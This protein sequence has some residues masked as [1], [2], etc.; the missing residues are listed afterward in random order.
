MSASKKILFLDD[1]SLSFSSPSTQIEL[2]HSL[3]LSLHKGE[4]LCLLGKSGIGKSQIFHSILQTLPFN[5]SLKGKIWFHKEDLLSFPS[6]IKEIRGRQIAT[7]FQDPES[8]L[9]PHQTIQT[10]IF[11]MLSLHR[12]LPFEKMRQRCREMFHKIGLTSFNQ[13]LQKFPHQLSGGQ[14]QRILIARALLCSPEILLADEPTTALDEKNRQRVFQLLLE[15]KKRGL[16]TLLI[17]HD[18]QVVRQLADRIALLHSGQ[19]IEEGTL[20]QLSCSP[21]HPYTSEFFSSFFE[22]PSLITKFHPKDLSSS[23]PLL[24]PKSPPLL[25]IENLSTPHLVKKN[26]LF[27]TTLQRPILQKIS[28]AINRGSSLGIWGESGGG[29]TTLAKSIM[30]LLAHSGK[31][32]LNQCLLESLPT[33]QL[34]KKRRQMQIIFQHPYSSLNPTK[35]IKKILDFPLKI[36]YPSLSQKERERQIDHALSLVHL[37]TEVKKLFPHELSG[38]QCQRVSIARSMIIHPELLICDEITSS[39][40]PFT[41]KQIIKLLKELQ[42]EHNMSLLFISHDSHAI[43]QLCDKVLF[44][45]EG[46]LLKKIDLEK[47]SLI[48]PLSLSRAL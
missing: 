1:L 36:H 26:S 30:Q 28:F 14:K 41:K 16:S 22:S 7:I 21:S 20:N 29:K 9:T 48:H 42:R 43:Q 32:L 23:Q 47:N 25:S 40:D 37:P 34:Q 2:I 13:I 35:Q 8:S 12:K 27:K 11:E 5:A 17:T 39:L 18:P 19:I 3:S 38:G 44:L 24:P 15:T 6:K 33:K 31:T 4:I 10:Q 45:H 46:I